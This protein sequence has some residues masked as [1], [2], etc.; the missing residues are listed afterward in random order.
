MAKDDDIYIGS[1]SPTIDVRQQRGLLE[2]TR[3]MMSQ[4]TVKEWMQIMNVYHEAI[5]RVFKENG[6]KE[7]KNDTSVI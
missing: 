2:V 6:I 4:L 5:N 3:S 1:V 7:D